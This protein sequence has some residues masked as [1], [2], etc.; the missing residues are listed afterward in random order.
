MLLTWWFIALSRY[1][2]RFVTRRGLYNTSSFIGG[3]IYQLTAA[4]CATRC[5]FFKKIDHIPVLFQ[6]EELVELVNIKKCS[7]CVTFFYCICCTML[8]CLNLRIW[9]WCAR[10][11]VRHFDMVIFLFSPMPH[12]KQL[13]I[14][15]KVKCFK[16]QGVVIIP[17]I[18]L[19]FFIKEG[20]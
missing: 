2:N 5:I 7:P 8:I 1:I 19:C 6:L 15:I 13:T 12:L 11:E 9:I 14:I 4:N 16:A 18:N 3:N 17:F 10:R 20:L